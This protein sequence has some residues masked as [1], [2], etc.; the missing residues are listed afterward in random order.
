MIFLAVTLGFFAESYREHLSESSK[1]KEFI[2]SM[3][4]DLKR[5]TA[6][7]RFIISK[8]KET[9]STI[10]TLILLFQL[11]DRDAQ[12][13]RMYY[14]ARNIT[15]NAFPFEIFD[16]TYSQM[17]TS[18]N[19]RLLH[20]QEIGDSITSYYSDMGL[21]V[22]QQ[23]FITTF[24]L[25]YIK[26]VSI[27]FDVSVLHNMY[28]E[29]GFTIN[30]NKQTDVRHLLPLIPPKGNPPLADKSKN[31]VNSLLGSSHYLYARIL[32]AC[33]IIGNE[34]KKAINLLLLLQRE[35]HLD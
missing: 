34:N 8:G 16:R 26:N 29:A 35:Y 19:L 11:P 30:S 27:V 33:L 7:F 1:E 4:D 3:V 20:S 23:N 14:H 31:A 13:S 22:S 32:N 21:L 28:K 17:K 9:A 2:K 6:N 5:D 25:D 24:L 15:R 18:G 12:T 10:D